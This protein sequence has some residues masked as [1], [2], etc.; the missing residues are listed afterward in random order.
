MYIMDKGCTKR[1]RSFWTTNMPRGSIF[2]TNL[3]NKD[4]TEAE[5]NDELLSFINSLSEEQIDNIL[6]QSKIKASIED[7]FAP[8]AED[9]TQVKLLSEFFIAKTS[10]ESEIHYRF[11]TKLSKDSEDLVGV[12]RFDGDFIASVLKMAHTLGYHSCGT[13]WLANPDTQATC[14]IIGQDKYVVEQAKAE[15]EGGH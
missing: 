1:L 13:N 9:S 10:F 11:T 7:V 3:N 15:I 14:L 2:L 6:S 5:F 8:I 4:C 12:A